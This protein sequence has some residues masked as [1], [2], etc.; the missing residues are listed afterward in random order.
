MGRVVLNPEDSLP[1]P[2]ASSSPIP[3]GECPETKAIKRITEVNT[4]FLKH[5]LACFKKKKFA[6]F[7]LHQSALA[8]F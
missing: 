5:T 4:V 2:A 8:C 6:Q 7:S 3:S 1:L